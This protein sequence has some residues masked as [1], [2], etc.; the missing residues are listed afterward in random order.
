MV[1]MNEQGEE[2]VEIE[3]ISEKR[4]NDPAAS[5]KVFLTRQD[6]ELTDK[7][8]VTSARTKQDGMVA[9][10]YAARLQHGILPKEG[11]EAFR[12]ILGLRD[13]PQ[14][15]VSTQDFMVSMAEAQASQ[16]LAAILQQSSPASEAHARPDLQTAY[17]VSTNP[18]EEKITEVWQRVLGIDQVGVHDNYFD[19]GG[20]SVQAIQIIAQLNQQGFQLTP[21]KLFQ[22]QTVAELAAVASQ[23]LASREERSRIENETSPSPS[24]GNGPSDFALAGLDETGLRELAGILVEAD[25]ESGQAN[26]APV[27]AGRKN[28][29]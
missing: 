2:L 25:T 19:L 15:I 3:E 8:P 29:A 16:P 24:S 4:I 23:L 11:R 28:R 18:L 1:L 22:H 21:Q 9:S 7:S 6:H 27:V 14:V 10:A 13:L 5:A 26:D 17:A 20:D 12:Y